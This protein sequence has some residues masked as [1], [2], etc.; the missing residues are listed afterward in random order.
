MLFFL[1]LE[2][3]HGVMSFLHQQENPCS[4]GAG[5]NDRDGD[6]RSGT[7]Q[8]DLSATSSAP[9]VLLYRRPG[10]TLLFVTTGTRGN[11]VYTNNGLCGVPSCITCNK[12]NYG[13]NLIPGKDPWYR[14]Y[15]DYTRKNKKTKQSCCCGTWYLEQGRVG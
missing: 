14:I 12:A 9:G 4:A 13:G 3:P 2:K 15:I 7:L 11:G 6:Q 1:F 10:S 5:R 8:G